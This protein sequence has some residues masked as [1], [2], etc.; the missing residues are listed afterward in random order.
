MKPLVD[1]LIEIDWPAARAGLGA[2]ASVTVAVVPESEI[3][4]ML[5]ALPEAFSMAAVMAEFV[6]AKAFVPSVRSATQLLP[7]AQNV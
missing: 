1:P 4:L 7:A 2:D 6:V 5:I 3:E